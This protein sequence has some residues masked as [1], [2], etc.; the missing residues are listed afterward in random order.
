MC[1]N[2]LGLQNPSGSK[3]PSKKSTWPYAMSLWD[4]EPSCATSSAPS[5]PNADSALNLTSSS[6]KDLVEVEVQREQVRR[7]SLTYSKYTG[8]SRTYPGGSFGRGIFAEVMRLFVRTFKLRA[9]EPQR[10]SRQRTALGESD[11]SET[12]GSDGR[13]CTCFELSGGIHV[14]NIQSWNLY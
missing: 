10:E 14:G 3:N 9:S 13:R 1:K 5:M 7:D 4:D 2:P 8:H 12:G 11:H 6:A